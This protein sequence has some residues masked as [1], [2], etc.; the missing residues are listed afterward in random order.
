VRDR[1]KYLPSLTC[2]R[3]SGEHKKRIAD[4]RLRLNA[5]LTPTDLPSC[6][7]EQLGH[8]LIALAESLT[9]R[10]PNGGARRCRSVLATGLMLAAIFRLSPFVDGPRGGRRA[11]DSLQRFSI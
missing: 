2:Q 7:S 8:E 1:S 10:P 5:E 11:V 6:R 9:R 3:S 4:A